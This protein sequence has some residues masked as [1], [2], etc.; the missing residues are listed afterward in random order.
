MI[1]KGLQKHTLLDYPHK[2][3]CTI[4]LFRCNFRC[5]YCHNPEL[6]DAKQASE[7]RTYS[8]KEILQFLKERKEFLEAVCITGGEPTLNKD[9]PEF[10]KE[11]KK[12]GYKI[13]LDT[14]GTNPEMLETLK[15]ENLVDYV[16]MD[17]KA[18]LRKY[19]EIANANADIK[20]IEKSISLVKDFPDYEFRITM[21]P[22]IASRGDLIEIAEY[23]KKQNA[24][25]RFFL[26]GFRARKCLDRSFE[27][28]KP[29]TREQM[30]EILETLK[31]YFGN[32]EIRGETY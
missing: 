22:K 4:F 3:A 6:V 7:L 31:P 29:Y 15:N 8:K 26:Q 19:P 1:I 2:V 11:I 20:K 21:L 16:S 10:M 23:L 14:N 27:N 32:I 5:G 18:P 13:K 30:A 28:E 25:R 24:N 17:F 9:L 12:L